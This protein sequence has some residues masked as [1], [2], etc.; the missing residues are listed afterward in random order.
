MTEEI[1]QLLRCGHAGA[2]MQWMLELGLLEVLLPEAYA[3]LAAGER[4]LGNFGQILPVIDRMVA[5]E[6]ELSDTALLAA[7]LLPKVLL[8]RYDVEAIDRRPMSRDALSVLIEEEVAP[9]LARFTVSNLKS[10]QILHALMGFQR[11]CEP[12]WKPAERVRFSRRPFFDDALFLFEVLVE[13]TGEGGEALAEWQAAARKRPTAVKAPAPAAR[14]PPPLRRRPGRAPAGA[15]AA[16][17]RRPIDPARD[18]GSQRRPAP[19]GR[20]PTSCEER[21]NRSAIDIG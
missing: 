19:S 16:A 3:M 21:H 5:A 20:L 9:F 14:A 4:G 7:L 2:A 18:G 8:R 12:V 6:R 11:L 1:A 10:Q 17:D 15:A 13:A